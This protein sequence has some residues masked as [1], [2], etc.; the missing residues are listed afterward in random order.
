MN[1]EKIKALID[2]ASNG[3]L[4]ELELVEG[5][6]RLRLSRGDLPKATRQTAPVSPPASSPM[7]PPGQCS[8]SGSPA[9]EAAPAVDTHI[10][11]SPMFGMLCLEPAPGEPPFVRIGDVV[12]KGQKL[13]LLEAMKVFHALETS[14]DGTIVAILAE[15]GQEVDSGQ[16][17]FRIE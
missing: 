12:R 1:L 15:N 9:M 6:C 7:P 3:G 17:L 11:K 13:C 5:D 14:R 8:A 2:L 16:A 10:V 4:S